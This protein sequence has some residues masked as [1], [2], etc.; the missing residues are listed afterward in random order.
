MSTLSNGSR[1]LLSETNKSCS[2]RLSNANQSW[3]ADANAV[4]TNNRIPRYTLGFVRLPTPWTQ[5]WVT[6]EAICTSAAFGNLTV[7][8]NVDGVQQTTQVLTGDARTHTYTVPLTVKADGTSVVELW[9]MW[10]G[11][12]GTQNSGTDK[13]QDGGWITGVNIPVGQTVSRAVAN[14]VG[15]VICGD[16]VIASVGTTTAATIGYYGSIAAEVQR[17]AQAKGW[18]MTLLAYGGSCF[19]GDGLTAANWATWIQQAVVAMGSPPTVKVLFNPFRNDYADGGTGV[20]TT[21]TQA[22]AFLT[23][24]L[25]L[26]P[27]YQKIVVTMFN[28]TGEGAVSGFTAPQW[29]TATA[30][31]ATAV[32]G[33]VLVDGTTNGVGAGGRM[34]D[35]IHFVAAGVAQALPYVTGPLGL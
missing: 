33:T 14:G 4:W 9:E 15:V 18:L 23:N 11:N 6:F 7:S 29:R 5:A 8:I 12:N 16:S 22:Q 17:R 21:P 34:P 19:C 25:Q 28:Q 31:A 10:S 32:P 24:V 30:A 20:N 2:I 3:I 13:P 27:A 26:L 35:G 1:V